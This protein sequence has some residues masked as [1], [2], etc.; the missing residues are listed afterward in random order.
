MCQ[1]NTQYWK[2]WKIFIKKQFCMN[3]GGFV[4]HTHKKE[5]WPSVGWVCQ[6]PSS[7]W[8]IKQGSS[9][10]EEQMEKHQNLALLNSSDTQCVSV[11]Q[12]VG[13]LL[14][15]FRS[16]KPNIRKKW[17][18]KIPK[19]YKQICLS[20]KDVGLELCGRNFQKP[21][22]PVIG[23]TEIEWSRN[24]GKVL[25]LEEYE[26]GRRSVIKKLGKR[27]EVLQEREGWGKRNYFGK[28]PG[29]LAALMTDWEQKSFLI[30]MSLIMACP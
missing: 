15:Y 29:V 9:P 7:V 2:N 12:S 17:S 24:I 10:S 22:C 25:N 8:T 6:W 1:I 21:I 11:P 26:A 23:R 3:R 5:K 16:E 19:G 4:C 18:P 30:L 27:F 13:C 14:N 20:G 28:A